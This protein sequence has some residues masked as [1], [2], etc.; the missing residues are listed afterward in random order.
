[1]TAAT[2]VLTSK[3]SGLPVLGHLQAYRKDRLRLLEACRRAPADVVELRIGRPTYV[4]KRPEDIKHVFVNRRDSYAKPSR[5]VGTRAKRIFGEGLM[6]SAEAPHR[7]MRKRVQPVFRE[8]S[9]ARLG[10]VAVRGVDA[11][12]DRWSDAEEI[13]LAGEMTALSLRTMATATFGIESEAELATIEEGLAARREAMSRAFD[14]LVEMPGF[15]PLALSPRRRRAISD[16]DR[17][18]D[19]AIREHQEGANGGEDLLAMMMAT[20]T[21]GHGGSDPERIRGESLTLVLAAYENVARALTWTLLALARYGSV[22]A[23]LHEE[24][25]RVLGGSAPTGACPELRY[26]DMVVAESMRLWPPTA[27]MF[28]IAL[29]DDVL[30][31]GTH[32]PSGSK[33]LISP[34][35]VQRD[36]RNFPDPE[37]FDPHRFDREQRRGRPQFA[38][39]P[40]GGGPRV[41][42][43][44]TLATLQCRLVVA[45]LA[46]RVRL[47]LAGSAPSYVCG[48]LPAGFGP[49][50]RVR[51]GGQPSE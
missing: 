25:R 42:I 35:I 31:A 10:D 47:E 13:D 8:R 41:C 29:E 11:M 3:P 27:L 20:Y 23:R 19:V 44:R 43:G 45:R 38:Y 16:L 2:P 4:L 12:V 9:I 46:Q 32:V 34:Y 30:P 28:R 36:P 33:L 48:C 6:T 18:L 51:L 24:V 17:R 21:G 40:F 49:A 7:P 37:R 26:T 5:N 22:Q 39:F 50:M 15:L 14:S 1:V